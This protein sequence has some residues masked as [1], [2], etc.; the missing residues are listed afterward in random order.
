MN[1][2]C[3]VDFCASGL[4]STANGEL[5]AEI[6]ELKVNA[7]GIPLLM[8]EGRCLDSVGQPF[9]GFITTLRT[10]LECKDALRNLAFDSGVVG[11]QI[12]RGTACLVLVESNVDT[13]AVQIKGGWGRKVN[14]SAKGR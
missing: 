14:E 1:A 12:Q 9:A 2:A 4:E 3:V 8:G 11:A 10:E 13:P 7:R 6:M 5:A